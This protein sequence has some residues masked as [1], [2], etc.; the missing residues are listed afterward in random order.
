MAKKASM[1]GNSEKEATPWGHGKHANM[2]TDV[3]MDAYPKAS[4]F[5]AGDLDDTMMEIDDTTHRAHTRSH[6]NL[7]NQH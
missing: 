2:P 1:H 4:E 7:S 5:G 3:H 6:K